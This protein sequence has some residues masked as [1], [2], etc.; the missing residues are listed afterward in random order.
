MN[1]IQKYEALLAN[2]K[3]LDRIAV[4]LSGGIDSTFLVYASKEALGKE[5]VL[6]I[7]INTSY[8]PERDLK[9]AKEFCRDL[10]IEHLIIDSQVPGHLR[11]NPVDRC[12]FCKRFEFSVVI[13]KAKEYN[14]NYVAAGLNSEDPSDY[15]PGISAMNELN[16]LYPLQTAALTKKE[17]RELAKQHNISSWNKPANACILSRI[18]YGDYITDETIHRI[19]EAEKILHNEGFKNPRVRTYGKFASIEVEKNEIVKFTDE[20]LSSKV[21]DAIKNLGYDHVTLDI[22]GYRTGSLNE[23]IA[24]LAKKH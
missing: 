17:I 16:V 2:I 1:I 23:G 14:I 10:N 4:A 15:R 19:Q 13:N 9:D 12:Y 11:P 18:P 3:S 6:A 20:E 24:T 8:L 22:R 7:T 5:N 21:Y